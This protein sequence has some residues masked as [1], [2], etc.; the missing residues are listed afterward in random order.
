MQPRSLD[1]AEKG[2]AEHR[3]ARV[4]SVVI[5]IAP[6][7]SDSSTASS[8]TYWTVATHLQSARNSRYSGARP[9]S[10]ISRK[11]IAAPA[12]KPKG[13]QSKKPTKHVSPWIRFHLWLNT[14]RYA[15]S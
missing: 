2:L 8:D 9:T 7:H 5:P 6:S 1:T 14:Y 10:K 11:S 15:F 4:F 13:L 12:G 3:Q